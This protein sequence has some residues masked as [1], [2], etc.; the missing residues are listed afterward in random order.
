LV[1]AR[2]MSACLMPI[3]GPQANGREQVL[4]GDSGFAAGDAPA[5]VSIILQ[6]L[7][8]KSAGDEHLLR[9][10]IFPIICMLCCPFAS[11]SSL[12][13]A[14]GGL[15]LLQMQNRVHPQERLL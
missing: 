2:T 13:F 1:G 5:L 8:L 3:R 7:I 4:H 9:P 6:E 11:C 10:C 14:S 12:A 15:S